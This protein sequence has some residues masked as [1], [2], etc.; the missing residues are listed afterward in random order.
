MGRYSALSVYN[1]LM[2]YT[3]RPSNQCG[4]TVFNCGVVPAKTTEI[5][6]KDFR[7]EHSVVS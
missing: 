6:Y 1:K 2:L 4:L 5:L 7:I 3:N